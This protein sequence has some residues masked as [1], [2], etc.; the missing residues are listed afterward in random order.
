MTSLGRMSNL[1]ATFSCSFLP[2][3]SYL[4]SKVENIGLRL[5]VIV[6]KWEMSKQS[7]TTKSPSDDHMDP[8]TSGAAS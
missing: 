8:Q 7:P 3:S 2:M 1:T 5:A 6:W 4:P